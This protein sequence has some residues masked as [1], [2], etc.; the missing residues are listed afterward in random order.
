MI[1][2]DVIRIVLIYW[3]ELNMNILR[4]VVLTAV[5]FNLTTGVENLFYQTSGVVFAEDD[6]KTEFDELSSKTDEAMN[7]TK[8]EVKVL[9]ERCDKL[10][11]RIETLDESARKVYLK[12]LQLSRDLFSFVLD[13]KPDQ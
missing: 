3:S 10:K 4:T 13:S 8:A 5:L 6:W 2:N 11:Q 7:L 12:R 9:V 1:A